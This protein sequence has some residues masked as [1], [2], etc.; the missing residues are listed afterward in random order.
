MPSTDPVDSLLSYQI[1]YD[2][3]WIDSS[4]SYTLY[5]GVYQDIKVALGKG[6]YVT[7]PDYEGPL[8]S[9]T[10]GHMAGYATLDGVRATLNSASLYSMPTN[11]TYAMWGYSGGAIATEW[12]TE[13]Q[14]EY[15]SD[16]TFAG[17]AMGGLT[18]NVTN[19]LLSIN[20]KVAAGLAPVSSF[21]PPL[22]YPPLACHD[23]KT[24]QSLFRTFPNRSN[25]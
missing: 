3:A 1:H 10:A 20:R 24:R 17:A 19:V 25:L 11:V 23:Q 2:S 7:V 5:G 15:A 16:L 22:P 18:P 8:A 4:P 21:P 13:L 14:S 12:A 6:Y 9:F